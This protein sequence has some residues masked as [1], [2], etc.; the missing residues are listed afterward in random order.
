MTDEPKH[1]SPSLDEFVSVLM[2]LPVA[3]RE[4]L[5]SA[6][7]DSVTDEDEE[8]ERAID[9]EAH[10]RAMEMERGE[11]AGVDADDV[12][13][14]LRMRDRDADVDALWAA[15]AHRRWEAFQRGEEQMLDFDDVIAQIRASF[16]R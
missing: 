6:L 16:P 4:Y 7:L 14:S 5:G 10:R 13:A 15:E 11:V 9:E 12:I 2:R 3:V 8:A 1:A